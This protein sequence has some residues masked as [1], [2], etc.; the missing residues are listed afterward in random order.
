[1]STIR[2]ARDVKA[3][4]SRLPVP[5]ASRALPFPA[6]AK[7]TLPNG[8]RVWTVRHVQV[9]LVAFTLLVRR[10]A[11]SDPAGKDGLAAVTADMLDEGS[12]GRSAI[13]IHE[14]LARLGAQFDTD[15]GSDATVASMTV[16]SR[17]AQP[18]LGLLSDIVA[19]PALRDVDFARVRELRLHRLT[20]LRDMPGALADRAFL[21]LLYGPHPYGH[22]PIGSEASLASMTVDDVRAFHARAIRPPA[23]TLIAV[24]DCEHD[25][26]VRLAGEAF[27][28]WDG[29]GDAE[30]AAGNPAL[31]APAITV[32]PRPRAPQSELRIG[33]VAAPRNTPDYHALVVANT[34]LGGQFVSRINLNLR[35]HKG[36]TYGARTAFEFRRLPGPFALQASVQT[37]G[38]AV[39]VQE[40]IGEIAGIRGSR[41][42]TD[43][44][45]ALGI[46][47]LTRGYARSFETAE[48]IGRAAM[49]IALYDLPDDYFAQFVSRIEAVTT[50][51]V[52]RVMT[53]HLDP[54]RLVTVV[55]G[56][57]EAVGAD[58]AAL[59]DGDPAVL[60]PDSI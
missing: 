57:L 29:A 44:E 35:E 32:V 16:L 60:A 23:A 36:L 47:A 42:V 38:T 17:F 8:M 52:S 24:G 14:A 21:K 18:V 55:V 33:Q 48:Q 11:S 9:P 53:R 43:E 5:G 51:D 27:A 46:A 39:A 41:P 25:D 4:R 59:A 12:G 56:D 22:S 26:I 1:M 28:D 2:T 54:A 7:S 10:G 15:I 20:Q 3:D 58:L 6:I 49:Q 19:R 30:V 13:E 37:S 34:I 40:S 50:Q 45:L 31:Q